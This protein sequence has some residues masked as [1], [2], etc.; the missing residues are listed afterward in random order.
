MCDALRKL[1]LD[2]RLKVL[3]DTDL[4]KDYEF[5]SRNKH[6]SANELEAKFS[7]LKTV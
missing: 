1:R 7:L 3:I 6:H 2:T 4:A 5:E